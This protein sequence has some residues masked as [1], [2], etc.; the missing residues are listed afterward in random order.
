M[1]KKEA[2]KKCERF[3]ISTFFVFV[4]F[5]GSLVVALFF[6]FFNSISCLEVSVISGFISCIFF[7]IL[8]WRALMMP[9]LYRKDNRKYIFE[10]DPEEEVD[11]CEFDDRVL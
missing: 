11:E 6:A 3:D 1:K 10:G 9:P 4:V 5:I 8:L 7:S 2:R